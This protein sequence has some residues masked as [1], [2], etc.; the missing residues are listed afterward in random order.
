MPNL[1]DEYKTIFLGKRDKHWNSPKSLSLYFSFQWIYFEVCRNPKFILLSYGILVQGFKIPSLV[2]EYKTIFLA[3]QGIPWNS[4]ES[5]YL[6]FRV[7]QIYFEVCQNPKSN[8]FSYGILV[9]GLKMP[10]LLDEYKT[11][12]LWKRGEPWNPPKTFSLYW[13]FL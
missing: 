2:N 5:F 9:Q 6:Y 12:F 10:N 11:I 1:V 3:K 4:P 8:L 7:L 13:S